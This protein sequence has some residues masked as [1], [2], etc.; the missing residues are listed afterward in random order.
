M[1]SCKT[2][3]HLYYIPSESAKRHPGMVKWTFQSKEND[4]KTLR[5]APSTQEAP[6]PPLAPSTPIISSTASSLGV[7]A[8]LCPS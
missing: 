1:L 5:K 8:L 4:S 2:H 7:K 3:V 6:R